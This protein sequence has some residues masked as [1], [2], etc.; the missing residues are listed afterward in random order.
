MN[1]IR[2]V[3]KNIGRKKINGRKQL[4]DLDVNGRIILK[5]ILRRVWGV[6]WIYFGHDRVQVTECVNHTKDGGMC[7]W[8][9]HSYCELRR[10][11]GRQR[12]MDNKAEMSRSHKHLITIKLRC[13]NEKRYLLWRQLTLLFWMKVLSRNSL[14]C[15]S[16]PTRNL[17][18]YRRGESRIGWTQIMRSTLLGLTHSKV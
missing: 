1:H 18:H 11:E 7:R 14:E 9:E 10:K 4:G 13:I 8:A 17:F 3:H 12:V 6:F 16:K 5:W 2:V 15:L